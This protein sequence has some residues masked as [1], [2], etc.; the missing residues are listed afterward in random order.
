MN[1]K[2]VWLTIIAVVLSFFG[3]FMLANSLNRTD[4]NT[5]RAE[6]KRGNMSDNTADSA[7]ETNLS[8]EEIRASIARADQDPENLG[9]QKNLGLALYRYAAM[10]QNPDLMTDVIRLLDRVL[11]KDPNDLEAILAL[12]NV[13]FDIGYFKKENK[14]LVKSREYYERIL[15]ERPTDADVRTDYGLTFFLTDPPESERAIAEYKKSLGN[16]P[17][18]EKSLQV[19]VQALV[20]IGKTDEARDYLTRLEEI[21]PKNTFLP[22]L[23]KQFTPGNTQ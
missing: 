6:S 13:Y 20:S 10:Q 21:N 15:K 16:N 11:E 17:K 23:K 2:F 18:H 8:A 7:G 19:L 3:G 4:L 12:G 9:L 5:L 14:M 1:T 22:E